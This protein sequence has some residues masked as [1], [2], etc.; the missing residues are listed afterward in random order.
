VELPKIF[1]DG[2]GNPATVKVYGLLNNTQGLQIVYGY[3]KG[4]TLNFGPVGIEN[5]SVCF[6]HQQSADNSIDPCPEITH[7]EDAPEYGGDFWT[8]TGTV[9]LGPVSVPFQGKPPAGCEGIKKLGIGF[10]SAGGFNLK[11]AALGVTGL[12]ATIFKLLTLESIYGGFE[13]RASYDK[14]VGCFVGNALGGLIGLSGEVLVVWVPQEGSYTFASTDLPDLALAGNVLT[15]H[16]GFGVGGRLSLKLPSVGE[17][18]FAN[19]YFLYVDKPSALLFGGGTEFSIPFGSSYE[20]PPDTG[21][22]FKTSIDGGV[23]FESLPP[24]F[25]LEGFMGVKAQ[26][27]LGNNLNGSLQG[28]VSD[29]GKGHGGIAV[30]GEASG[31]IF[32]WGFGP[33]TAGFGYHWGDNVEN[34]IE[35]DI[36][37]GGGCGES[38]YTEFHVNVQSAAA[39]RGRVVHVPRGAHVVDLYLS[40]SGGA[41][42]VTIT[43]PGGLRAS[44]AGTSLTEATTIDGVLLG[45]MP[46]GGQSLLVLLHPRAGAY[47]ITPNPGSPSL[48][49][50]REAVAVS[51][52]ATGSV[53]GRGT[54]KRLRYRIGAEP[55][56]TVTFIERFKGGV[57]IL[58]NA[59][60]IRGSLAFRASPGRGRRQIIAQFYEAGMPAATAPVTSYAAPAFAHLPRVRGLR[61][62]RAGARA[63]IRFRGVAGAHAYDIY[64]ELTD[65]TRLTYVTSAHRLS[66]GPFFLSVGGRVLVRA[67]GDGVYTRDGPPAT[68][69]LRPAVNV[70]KKRRHPR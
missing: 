44:T 5:F 16:L 4:L 52:H 59:R 3:L 40:G 55:G 49:Q 67:A 70:R 63:M 45:R 11:F 65:G 62:G 60:S 69:T 28:I 9:K 36:H 51:P 43:G 15:E 32:G 21:I 66:V 10:N 56:Q 18:P 2:H 42:D 53:L 7:I 68:S 23:G 57:R 17:V 12:N 25:F 6:R 33:I 13:A 8:I 47:R 14:A 20:H 37:L 27:P 35:H 48:R 31:H 61:V 41:P 24:P 29:D 26:A 58:G 38:W 39:A 1:S 54:H 34:L 22:A 30:C 64:V 19:A 50:L 46:T